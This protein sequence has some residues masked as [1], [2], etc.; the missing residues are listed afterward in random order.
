M[1]DTVLLFVLA[2]VSFVVPLLLLRLPNRINKNDISY[3][4]DLKKEIE[5]QKVDEFEFKSVASPIAPRE[6]NLT[7]DQLE[8]MAKKRKNVLSEIL[9]TEQTY[10]KFYANLI[11]KNSSLF[12]RF[13]VTFYCSYPETSV[14]QPTNFLDNI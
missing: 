3:Q 2:G 11:N 5:N 14:N 12:E 9:A 13:I 6:H 4:L 7:P 1:F 8:K 10:G